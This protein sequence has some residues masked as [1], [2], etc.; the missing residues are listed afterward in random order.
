MHNETLH[1]VAAIAVDVCVV[2]APVAPRAAVSVAWPPLPV[3]GD[4]RCCL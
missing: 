3:A 1:V 2:A 4:G